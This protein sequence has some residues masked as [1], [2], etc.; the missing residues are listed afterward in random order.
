MEQPSIFACLNDNYNYYKLTN[1][2]S[3]VE[4]FKIVSSPTSVLLVY[5]K[6]I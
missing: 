2:A 1:F 5:Y 3:S 4:N 6:K